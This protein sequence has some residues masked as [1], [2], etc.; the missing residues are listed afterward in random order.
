MSVDYYGVLFV[1]R[2]ADAATIKKAYRKL[3][4][5]YHPDRNPDDAVAETKFKECAEA[6]EVLS[7]P[8]KRQVYDTYGYEGLQNNGHRGPSNASDIFSNFGDVF[9]R[10][11]Q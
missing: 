10:F 4:M 7:D 1:E 3:A 6:Y 5:K 11:V 2:S 8:Q 9:S